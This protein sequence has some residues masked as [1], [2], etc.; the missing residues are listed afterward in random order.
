MNENRVIVAMSGGVDSSVAAAI[1][2]KE[3]YDV[4]GITM[5]TWGF[6]EVGGAPKH[7][8]GCCSLDA[9]FDAKNVAELIGIPHYTV[10]FTKAFEETVIDDFVKEYLAGRTPNPCVVCNRKI[11]W[12]ELLKKADS[13]D[14]RYVA[15]GHYA[16]VEKINDRYTLKYSKDTKKDQTYALWGLT[17]ESLSRTLFPLGKY[18][19]EEV[20][21]IAAEFGLKTADKPDS[22]EIC[23]VADNNYERFL[24]ERIPEVINNIREGNLVYHGEIVGKH[25]GFPFYTIGQRRGLGVS[26]GKPVYVKNIDSNTNTIEIGDKEEL[27]E[28]RVKASDVNY[29]SQAILKEGEK[30]FG[31]IRYS[32]SA[33]EAV[34]IKSAP[35][36]IEI[37]FSEPKNAV[38]PGQSLVLYDEK[39]YLLAGGIIEK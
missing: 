5:K 10:D 38:T 8:S 11:K 9:I 19:K 16:V 28:R 4:I 25:K 22:Q 30:V 17:Q 26:F 1:L 23:F 15:T 18:T 32:D 21:A 31:K 37:E 12:E 33:K 27:L 13:L 35:D 7:E 29:V 6:M 24:R 14:A 2:K 3:G 34:V 39:G 36:S 20:R